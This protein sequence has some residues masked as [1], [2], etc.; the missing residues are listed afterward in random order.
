MVGR[1]LQPQDTV[2]ESGTSPSLILAE[3]IETFL[4]ASGPKGRG[5]I[6]RS[7]ALNGSTAAEASNDLAQRSP[8]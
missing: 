7:E 3:P 5:I 1:R 8:T 4:S 6:A 2:F